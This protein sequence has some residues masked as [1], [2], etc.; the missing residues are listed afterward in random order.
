MLIHEQIPSLT[1]EDNVSETD[2]D[3]YGD[4]IDFDHLNEHTLLSKMRSLIDQK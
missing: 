3:D 4:K 1:V 2:V